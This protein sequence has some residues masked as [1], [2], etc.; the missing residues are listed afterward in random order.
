M[1]ATFT[2]PV[3]VMFQNSSNI[4]HLHSIFDF[5]VL[6]VYMAE[7]FVLEMRSL[8]Q[9]QLDNAAKITLMLHQDLNKHSNP[10]LAFLHDSSPS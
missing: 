9:E 7:V 8:K 10:N 6:P 1:H 5:P 2:Y 4:I 3:H